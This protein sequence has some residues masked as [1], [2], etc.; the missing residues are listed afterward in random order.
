MFLKDSVMDSSTSN[1]ETS[2]ATVT[3]PGVQVNAQ[4]IKDLSFENP[5]TPGTITVEEEP[6][7]EV[8]IDVKGS[9]LDDAVYEVVLTLSAI[10]QSADTKLFIAELSY[11]GIFALSNIKEEDV[12]PTLLISCPTLLFPFARNIIA[13]V[14]RDGGFPPL[15]MQPVDFH[16]LYVQ[17]QQ[18]T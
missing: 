15:L 9:K 7:I 18:K 6:N 10:G 5:N 13:D 16:Q 3:G 1:S 2:D 4:Y 8:N 14:T 11:A 17:S 12:Q